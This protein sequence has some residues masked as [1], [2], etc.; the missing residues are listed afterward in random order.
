MKVSFESTEQVI[1][2]TNGEAS[3]QARVWTGRTESG[4]EVQML[5]VRIAADKDADLSQF[6]RDLKEQ[7]APAVWPAAFPLRM[8][9]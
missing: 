4:V 6:E 9:I 1:E 7:H 8:I 5:V 3:I 2:L